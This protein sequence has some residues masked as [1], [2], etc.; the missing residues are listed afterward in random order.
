MLLAYES[1]KITFK[2]FTFL[3]SLKVTHLYLY[4]DTPLSL[5]VLLTFDIYSSS[6]KFCTTLRCLKF[7]AKRRGVYSNVT[8]FLGGVN[9]ALLVAHV[10]QLFPNAKPSMLVLRFLRVYTNWRWLNPVMLCPVE[11]DDLGLDVWDPRKLHG[12]IKR[13]EDCE[14]PACLFS[15]FS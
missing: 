11:E 12:E 8:G 4:K 2:L 6:L 10:C 15:S 1:L 7:W 13:H 5:F 14:V 9:S 3:P